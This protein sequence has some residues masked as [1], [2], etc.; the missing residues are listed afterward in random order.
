MDSINVVRY[1]YIHIYP[2]I[3]LH[4]MYRILVVMEDKIRFME[5]LAAVRLDLIAES[6]EL[7]SRPNK[8]GGSHATSYG[9]CP[10]YFLAKVVSTTCCPECG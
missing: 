6:A 9:V 10:Q 7:R 8:C 3:E 5:L 2:W 4:D 1:M